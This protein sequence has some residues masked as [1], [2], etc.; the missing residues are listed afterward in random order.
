MAHY[1][2]VFQPPVQYAVKGVSVGWGVVSLVSCKPVSIPAVVGIHAG[3]ANY[4]QQVGPSAIQWK[5]CRDTR[6]L[7][8]SQSKLVHSCPAFRNGLM[9]LT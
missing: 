7:M 8:S 3:M 5:V 9:R 4:W 6:T 2:T 1:L